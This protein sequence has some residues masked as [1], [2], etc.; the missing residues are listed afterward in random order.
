MRDEV[1]R[2]Q[3]I[4]KLILMIGVM[5]ITIGLAFFLGIFKIDF[6]YS[7]IGAPVNSLYG[8]TY[9][10]LITFGFFLVIS[11]LLLILPSWDRESRKQ[12]RKYQKLFILFGILGLS[13]IL[14]SLL[15]YINILPTLESNQ[16]WFDY[17]I[18]GAIISIPNYLAITFSIVNFQDLSKYNRIW[19]LL[20]STGIVIE[21]LSLLTYWSLLKIIGMSARSWGDLYLFGAVFL[22][23]GGLPLLV[24]YKQMEKR[25]S[26]G[27]GIL[28]IV[29]IISGI[30]TYL[31]PTLALNGIFF[32]LS[33]FRYN[34]YFDFLYFGSLILIIGISIASNLD[35]KQKYLDKFP[36]LWGF[37]L[38]LGFIQYVISILMEITDSF[39]IDLGLDFLF[40]KN[41]HGSALFGMTWN[42]FLVNSIVT[43]LPVLIILSSLILNESKNLGEIQ[44]PV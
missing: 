8:I 42:V 12:L 13:L 16:T 25:I 11:S 19:I 39:F 23:M 36:V 1:I 29:L 24:S 28:S 41:E 26:N 2:Y 43:T 9:L 38:I 5:I 44:D 30:V 3:G 4:L 37:F 14:Y 7:L 22:F 17:F 15:V 31:A 21:L 34:R 6:E 40:A 27:L 33:I 32:P 35:I 10:T 18:I 20:I